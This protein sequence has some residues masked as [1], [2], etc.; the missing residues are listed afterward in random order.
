MT[1]TSTTP[2]GNITADLMDTDVPVGLPASMPTGNNSATPALP[3]TSVSDVMA[4]RPGK[5]GTAFCSV[6]RI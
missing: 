5:N 4:S 3:A 6:S 1:V 2:T